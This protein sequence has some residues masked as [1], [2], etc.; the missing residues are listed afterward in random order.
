MHP[1]RI[2]ILKETS[3]FA[4]YLE[5]DDNGEVWKKFRA[6]NYNYDFRISDGMFARWGKTKESIDDPEMS[7]FGPEI[8]DFEITDILEKR[9]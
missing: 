4:I 7:P 5:T 8:L 3:K 2:N 9:K 1:D 6:E